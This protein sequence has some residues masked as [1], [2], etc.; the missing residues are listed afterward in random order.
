M[1]G[2]RGQAAAPWTGRRRAWLE[3]PHPLPSVRVPVLRLDPAE[4]H[5]FREAHTHHWVILSRFQQRQGKLKGKQKRMTCLAH[6]HRGA[7]ASR[8]G[9]HIPQPK[10]SL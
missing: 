1:G 4:R 7:L 3:A 6:Q 8:Q 10:H 9:W 5:R 2:R